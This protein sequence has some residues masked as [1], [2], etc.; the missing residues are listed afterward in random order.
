VWL[1]V[2]L[3]GLL[4]IT[5][6]YIVRSCWSDDTFYCRQVQF[7][8]WTLIS[9]DHFVITIQNWHFYS[10][11]NIFIILHS[12]FKTDDSAERMIVL[13]QAKH[14]VHELISPIWQ[15]GQASHLCKSSC[16]HGISGNNLENRS[17]WMY[18]CTLFLTSPNNNGLMSCIITLPLQLHYHC[19]CHCIYAI[20]AI[21][22]LWHAV[23]FLLVLYTSWILHSDWWARG[24]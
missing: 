6:N 11:I 3:G 10:I 14:L 23:L 2:S 4:N 12:F 8:N 7:T 19:H 1:S 13:M 17:W 15:P 20:I 24:V 9:V 21:L 5:P 18:P 22:A 16:N